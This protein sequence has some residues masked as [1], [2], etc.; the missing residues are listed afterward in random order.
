MNAC[1]RTH[2]KRAVWASHAFVGEVERDDIQSLES[3]L[4][5]LNGKRSTIK[6]VCTR[7]H[8]PQ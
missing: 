2:G 5:L 3:K 1:I 7:G 4:R 8:F 6:M